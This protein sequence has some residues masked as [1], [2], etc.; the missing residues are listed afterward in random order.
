MTVMTEVLELSEQVRA[1]ILRERPDLAVAADLRLLVLPTARP[2]T[3]EQLIGLLLPDLPPSTPLLEQLRRNAESRAELAAEWGVLSAEEVADLLGS[4]A[5][6][7]AAAASRLKAQGRLFSVPY[8]SRTI[9]PAFQFAD[10]LL[11]PVV[12]EV[13]AALLPAGWSDWEIA[14]WFTTAN[15]RLGDRRPVDALDDEAAIRRAAA[16]DADSA[17]F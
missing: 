15:G 10:G 2:G 13:L 5:R 6:N 8:R 11:R 9:F 3:A 1:A 12:A 17:A 14:L 7:R 16:L 4:R